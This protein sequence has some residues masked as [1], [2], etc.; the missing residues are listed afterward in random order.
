[1]NYPAPSHLTGVVTETTNETLAKVQKDY[2]GNTTAFLFNTKFTGIIRTWSEEYD[3][4]GGTIWG[5]DTGGN[6]ILLFDSSRHGYDALME[7]THDENLSITKSKDL[8]QATSIVMAFQYNGEEE[9]YVEG[10]QSKFKQDYFGWVA[11]YL[12][13][14]GKLQ[15]IFDYECA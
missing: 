15:L 11:I 10:G 4:Y 12:E 3:S 2:G 14:N 8:D 6:K 1:M 13:L 9:E 7:L 5:L